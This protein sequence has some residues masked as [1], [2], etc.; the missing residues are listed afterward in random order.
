[1]RFY[2][3]YDR[4]DE[5]ICPREYHEDEGIVERAG[6]MSTEQM[7]N[8]LLL[9]GQ[10]LQIFREAEFANGEEIPDD[11]PA[12]KYMV[13]RLDAQLEMRAV[14]ERIRVARQADYEAAQAAEA[15]RIKEAGSAGTH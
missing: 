3:A 9:A 10:N 14:A 1:M 15:L 4:P 12:A 2:T 5:D 11:S 7:V 6:Y 13:D 8:Q